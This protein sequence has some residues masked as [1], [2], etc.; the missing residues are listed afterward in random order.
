MG[1]A[2]KTKG[3]SEPGCTLAAASGG[4]C[5]LHYIKNWKQVVEQKKKSAR[6]RLNKY[7]ENLSEKYPGEYLEMIKDDLEDE[8]AFR[9]RL[10]ELGFREELEDHK[11]SPFRAE[12]VED[13]L[14]GLKFEDE[15]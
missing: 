13:L 15:E 10:R 9:R 2:K 11:D 6:E 14:E 3:C 8:G 5:R 12:K 7:I 4:F 1:K